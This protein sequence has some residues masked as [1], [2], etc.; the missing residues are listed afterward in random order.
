[1][2]LFEVAALRRKTVKKGQDKYTE[3]T[4]LFGPVAVVAPDEQ[5]AREEA[6][7]EHRDIVKDVPHQ[8]REVLVRPFV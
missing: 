3:E 8:L 2:P 5:A 6:L 1:M 7:A 4:L